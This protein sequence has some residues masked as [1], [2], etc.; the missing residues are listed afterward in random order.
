MYV[1]VSYVFFQSLAYV[2]QVN[3]L[4]IVQTGAYAGFLKGGGG[5][6]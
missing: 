5:P 4:S 6:T 3:D 2:T 1:L